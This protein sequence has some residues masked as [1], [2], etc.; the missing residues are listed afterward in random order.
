MQAREPPHQSACHACVEAFRSQQ[1]VHKLTPSFFSNTQPL[2]AIS[3][4]VAT[5]GGLPMTE[6]SSPAQGRDSGGSKCP[7][8]QGL[9][10]RAE[11]VRVWACTPVALGAKPLGCFSCQC[12]PDTV[13]ELTRSAQRTTQLQTLHMM[14][15][16]SISMPPCLPHSL[17][18]TSSS[19]GSWHPKS[20]GRPGLS[21]QGRTSCVLSAGAEPR[22]PAHRLPGQPGPASLMSACSTN[23]NLDRGDDLVRCPRKKV[24][25]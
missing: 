11:H 17:G 19:G 15:P 18:R 6:V 24:N 23:H 10:G 4:A 14:V 16:A 1:Q 22:H 7:C 13:R 2:T 3:R 25:D 5:W 8:L 21:F 9:R 20:A 12:Q